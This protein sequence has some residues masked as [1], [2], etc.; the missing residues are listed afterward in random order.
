MNGGLLKSIEIFSKL[1]FRENYNSELA[2]MGEFY[3]DIISLISTTAKGHFHD[4][5]KKLM[6]LNLTEKRIFDLDIFFWVFFKLCVRMP[7]I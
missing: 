7:V 2:G 6:Y 1:I 5:Y 3:S 4:Y